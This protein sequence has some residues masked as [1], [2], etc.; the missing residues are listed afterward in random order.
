MCAHAHSPAMHVHEHTAPERVPS[1]AQLRAL[2]PGGVTQAPAR[3][4]GPSRSKTLRSWAVPQLL[5]GHLP[6]SV[7]GD[8]Q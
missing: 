6:L 3:L 7:L 1:P 5:L 2:A 8:P 4:H